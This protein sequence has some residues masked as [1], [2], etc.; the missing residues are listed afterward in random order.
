[1]PELHA[2]EVFIHGGN[3]PFGGLEPDITTNVLSIMFYPWDWHVFKPLRVLGVDDRVQELGGEFHPMWHSTYSKDSSY[4]NVSGGNLTVHVL[5]NDVALVNVSNT[6]LTVEVCKALRSI[7]CWP[8]FPH[9]S[10]PVFRKVDKYH[11][12]LC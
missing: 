6:S 10:Q 12:R 11:I 4:V 2:V 5:D 1:M 3:A 8:C 9:L 7:S